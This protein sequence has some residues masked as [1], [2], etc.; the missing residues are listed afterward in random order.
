MEEKL[1]ELRQ[2]ISD[3]LK[4]YGSIS[5]LAR[6]LDIDRVYLHRLFKGEKDNPLAFSTLCKYTNYAHVV[7]C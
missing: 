7:T 4:D 2:R 3:L 6:Q 5:N 1:I